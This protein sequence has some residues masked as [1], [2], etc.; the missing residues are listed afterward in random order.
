MA[1]IDL[2]G[3]AS[4]E[5]AELTK[6]L[7]YLVA[8]LFE[9]GSKVRQEPLRGNAVFLFQ[10]SGR[11]AVAEPFVGIPVAVSEVQ[12]ELDDNGDKKGMNIEYS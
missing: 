9:I 6:V 10:V 12:V 11:S 8:P 7:P 1:E 4:A 2:Q 3:Q 5:E